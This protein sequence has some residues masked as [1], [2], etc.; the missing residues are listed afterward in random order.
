MGRYKRS[1][2][3]DSEY[4]VTGQTVEVTLTGDP[5]WRWRTELTLCYSSP[6]LFLRSGATMVEP[7][8]LPQAQVAV[9][10]PIA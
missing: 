6:P 9:L 8:L 4:A 1:P 7:P 10:L 2:C 3:S 5:G